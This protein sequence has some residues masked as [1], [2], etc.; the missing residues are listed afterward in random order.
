MGTPRR[1]NILLDVKATLDTIIV[2]NGYKT[3][4]V[5]VEQYVRPYEDVPQ[6]QRPYIGFAT[7]ME[8]PEH[9]PFGG[10][11]WTIPVVVVGYVYASDWTARSAAINNLVDDVIAALETD[12][13]RGGY[14]ISTSIKGLETNESDPDSQGDGYLIMDFEIAYE[15]TTSA[16]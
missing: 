7:G 14:A 9:R 10:M 1:T 16:S 13:T 3:A 2:A 11:H 4:T 15:R 5:T 8:I 6:A 12:T